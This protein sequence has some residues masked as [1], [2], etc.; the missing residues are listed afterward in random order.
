MTDE[1]PWTAERIARVAWEANR[2]LQVADADPY[3]D[4]PWDAAPE[5][6]KT[7]CMLTVANVCTGE[8]R[9]AR[10]AH[11]DWRIGMVNLGWQW[12][13]E[14]NPGNKVHPYLIPWREMT[15]RAQLGMRL[16]V[17]ITTEIM[18]VEGYIVID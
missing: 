1:L 2:Q 4:E 18:E 9:H 17:L 11:D 14:K 13:H 3:P 5:D 8:I 7:I 12:N 15:P 16:L 6:L 10:E